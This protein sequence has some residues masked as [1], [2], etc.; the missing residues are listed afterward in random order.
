MSELKMTVMTKTILSLLIIGLL[1]GCR[2]K[3]T[4]Y[5]PLKVDPENLIDDRIL[6]I[7]V[8]NWLDENHKNFAHPLTLDDLD[9]VDQ[10]EMFPE[11]WVL[12]IGLVH[13]SEKS[14][15]ELPK[16][17]NL[18][19]LNIQGFGHRDPLKITD[20]GAKEIAKLQQLMHLE[21]YGVDI[22]DEGFKEL[23]NLP[24]LEELI[25]NDTKITDT[26]LQSLAALKNLKRL[27]IQLNQDRGDPQPLSLTKVVVEELQKALPKCYIFTEAF[28]NGLS[29]RTP[30]NTTK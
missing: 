28:G 16:L 13:L 24:R 2:P 9:M 30:Y 22:T 19:I 27:E 11:L 8:L 25:L 10:L 17:K 23:S 1:V 12:G 6:E 4:P 29:Y 3:A 7:A 21:L 26:G 20:S 5:D 15:K 18:Q 14:L